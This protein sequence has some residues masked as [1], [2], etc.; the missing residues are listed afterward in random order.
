MTKL[1]MLFFLM[2]K[3]N[4]YRDQIRIANE[5]ERKMAGIEKMRQA[6]DKQLEAIESLPGAILREVFDFT[7]DE[8]S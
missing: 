2:M 6:A 1:V 8:D 3:K 5:I 4:K 7:E